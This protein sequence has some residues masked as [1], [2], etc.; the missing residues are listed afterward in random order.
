MLF[1]VAVTYSKPSNLQHTAV[2][3]HSGNVPM[4]VEYAKM[5]IKQ[6]FQ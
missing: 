2:V 5:L 6:C 3:D 4:A 1:R